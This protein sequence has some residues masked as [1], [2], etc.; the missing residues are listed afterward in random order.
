MRIDCADPMPGFHAVTPSGI[1]VKEGRGGVTRLNIPKI[2]K[3]PGLYPKQ[4]SIFGG[5]GDPERRRNKNY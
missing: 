5:S 1:I 3:G 4:Q 2:Q